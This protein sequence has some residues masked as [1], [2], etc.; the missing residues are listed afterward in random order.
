[1]VGLATL[2][3]NDCWAQALARQAD[4]A[5]RPAR[6]VAV[7]RGRVAVRDDEGEALLPVLVREPALVGDWAGVRDGAVRAILERRTLLERDGAGQVA[8]ADLCIAVTSLNQDLNVRRAERFLALAHA[9]GVEALVVLSKGDLAQDP[10]GDAERVA[11]RLSCEVIVLSAQDGWGIPGLRARLAPRRT[12]V[13]VGTSGAGKST[14][15]NLLLGEQRQRVLEIRSGDDRGRHATTHRELFVLD[16]GS[17]LVDTP[18]VRRP[19]MVSTDGLDETF[20]EIDELAR[21]CR[22]ADCRH[23]DEPGC[24]V[25]AA[26]DAGELDPDRLASLRKLEREGLSAQERR[27]QAR[28]FHRRYRKDIRARSR[29]R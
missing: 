20:A 8:N 7:H 25:R 11:R 10:A 6:V 29:P 18:G 14:L 4:D 5:L 27:E 12:S 28:D 22:F 3:W 19:G 23:E 26:I 9:G 15:V 24:A 16:D 1:M 2:G 17:L 21:G 13:L